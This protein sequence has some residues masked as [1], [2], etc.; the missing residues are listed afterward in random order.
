MITRPVPAS[1]VI[2]ST[3]VIAF[4]LSV[5]FLLWQRSDWQRTSQTA[6]A[7]PP[8]LLRTTLLLAE[9]R[10]TKAPTTA[11]TMAPAA[12]LPADSGAPADSGD[13]APVLIVVRNRRRLDVV[14]AT[15]K[16]TS[17]RPVSLTLA[18][19][20]GDGEIVSRA[21]LELSPG[22]ARRFGASDGIDLPRGGRIRVT[23]PGHVDRVVDIPL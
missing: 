10:P 19:E 17:D 14:E 2:A 6:V 8:P 3:M 16:N 21:R 15:A 12:A 11:P 5:A 13:D 1:V 9:P 22:E 20:D 23:M 4:T 7:A 18:L